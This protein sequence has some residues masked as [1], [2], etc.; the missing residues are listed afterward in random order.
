MAPKV[1]FTKDEMVAAAVQVVRNGGI[2]RLTAKSLAAQLGTSTQ[3]IFTCFATMDAVKAEVTAAAERIYDGY[4]A[5]GLADPRPFFGFGMQYIQFA[6]TEPQLYRLLFLNPDGPDGGAMAAMTHSLALVR[7][8][9]MEIYRITA[10][11]ADC[12]FRDLW[13]VVHG[14]ATLIVTG[15]CPY[16]DRDIAQMLTEVSVS[17]CKAIKEIP[18]FSDGT[19]DRDAVFGALIGAPGDEK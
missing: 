7:P 9:M 4:A 3:P 17:I 15:S 14:L 11:E 19:F 8:S 5:K 2:D 16:S 12:Y 10:A 13:L 18:G 6:R 1:K